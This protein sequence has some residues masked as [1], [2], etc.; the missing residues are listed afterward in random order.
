MSIS[1]LYIW[2]RGWGLVPRLSAS[3][4]RC[5]HLTLAGP[6]SCFQSNSDETK[7]FQ[8]L[9]LVALWQK[10]SAVG[11]ETKKVHFSYRKR[12]AEGKKEVE[13][14]FILLITICAVK[15]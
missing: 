10:P 11:V 4:H 12:K 7:R 1:L 2:I 15:L 6:M 13:V 14:G 3:M 5:G 9:G 8:P